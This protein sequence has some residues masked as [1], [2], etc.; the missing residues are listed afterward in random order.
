MLPDCAER[1]EIV[2]RILAEDFEPSPD[3][4]REARLDLRGEQIF[5]YL[6]GPPHCE[7]RRGP[8]ALASRAETLLAELETRSSAGPSPSIRG[9]VTLME[10]HLYWISLMH[11]GPE[12]LETLLRRIQDLGTR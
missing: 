9:W 10:E 6:Y 1:A 11:G 5:S 12:D 4:V 2:R 8:T 3:L 7:G